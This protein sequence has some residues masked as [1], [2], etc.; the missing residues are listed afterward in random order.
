MATVVDLSKGNTYLASL[1]VW[2]M[3]VKHG[4][5]NIL[6]VWCMSGVLR[7]FDGKCAFVMGSFVWCAMCAHG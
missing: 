1:F 5:V 3:M 4:L 7:V 6:F 2:C